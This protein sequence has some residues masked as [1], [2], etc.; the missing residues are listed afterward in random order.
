MRVPFKELPSAGQPFLRPVLEIGLAG[1][2]LRLG[3]LVDTGTLHNRFAGWTAQ[4]LGVGLDDGE[5]T[6]L[7][8]GGVVAEAVTVPVQMTLGEWTWSAPVSFC[9]PWPFGFQ[10]LGQEGF[11][12]FFR[13][14]L[15]ASEHR[16]EIEPDSGQP[17]PG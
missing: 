4:V 1:H 9:E 17:P 6:R 16:L 2:D 11:L 8:L 13:V 3:A 7:A 10:L 5:R 15:V 12:R 14:L